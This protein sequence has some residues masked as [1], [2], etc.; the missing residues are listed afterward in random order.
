MRNWNCSVRGNN[1]AA[2]KVTSGA[3]HREPP[4]LRHPLLRGGTV[5]RQQRSAPPSPKLLGQIPQGRDKSSCRHP[6]P[7][8]GWRGGQRRGKVGRASTRP[9]AGALRGN[10]EKTCFWTEKKSCCSNKCCVYFP[11]LLDRRFLILS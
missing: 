4:A 10:G 5:L 1:A 7:L 3:W 9:S 6:R 2:T 8:P 11:F